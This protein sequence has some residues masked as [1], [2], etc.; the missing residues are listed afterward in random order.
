MPYPLL[1]LGSFSFEGLESPE[2]IQLKTRQRL[3][4]H[5]LGSGL[6]EIEY[7]G[8]DY[9]TV[10][11]RGIFCGANAADRIRSI[12]YFRVQ[13]IPLV[14]SWT[15]M[16]LSVVIRQFELDYSSDR[17]IRYSLSCYIVRSING[18]M[19]D[20]SGTVSEAPG[21][22][23]SDVVGLL[24]STRV[25]P[26]SYQ[27]NALLSLATLHFDVAP[28]DALSRVQDLVQS[29]D[30]CLSATNT[31][32]QIAMPYGQDS[33]GGQVSYMESLVT[34]YGQQASLILGRN[35]VMSV[36]TQAEDIGR[37]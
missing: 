20:S 30:D 1:T 5:H 3:A 14:L 21:T 25:N 16:A 26:T 19:G 7:L 13:G 36:M 9:E 32:S 6:S 29:I 15:S 11:F 28:P 18:G 37:Q 35:R 4:V 10:S 2:Q 12:D 24:S 22:Q 34:N 8:N 27:A 17:W 33:S 23:V 31:L